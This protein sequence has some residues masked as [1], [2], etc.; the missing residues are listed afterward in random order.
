MPAPTGIDRVEKAYIRWGLERGAQFLAGIDRRQYVVDGDVVRDLIAWLDGAGNAPALDWRAIA[1]PQRDQRLRRVQSLIRKHGQALGGPGGVYLNVGHDNLTMPSLDGLRRNGWKS[2]VMIHDTIPLDHPQ[3]ARVGSLDRFKAL[4]NAAA[5][6]DK[7]IANSA[8]TARR[9]AD[10]LPSQDAQSVPLGIEQP[11]QIQ[12]VG[13]TGAFLCIGTIEPRKNHAML[14]DVWSKL[15]EAAPQLRI[16]G[17]RGWRNEDVFRRLDTDP[18]MGRTV[19]EIG[20]PD[21]AKLLAEIAGAHAVLFPSLA[22]GFGLPLAEALALGT[23]VLASDLPALREVGGNVP[24]WLVADDPDA[25]Q[26]AVLDYAAEPSA[27]RQEQLDRMGGWSAPTWDSHFAIVD[28]IVEKI[29]S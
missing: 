8:D 28:G 13:Q 11:N 7:V 17:R 15:G 19:H 18:M 29:A 21:D 5:G 3:F 22:E 26:A 24:D 20:T 6:A 16:I 12:N 14:L 27:R 10:Y 2:I 1:R 23:P 25:W 4:L 9:L